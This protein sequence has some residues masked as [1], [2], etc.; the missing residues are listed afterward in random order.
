MLLTQSLPTIR[1]D[2]FCVQ[3][4]GD[5]GENRADAGSAATPSSLRQRP[6]LLTRPVLFIT[7]R[8]TGDTE[9][10]P[11]GLFP[12]GRSDLRGARFE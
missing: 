6:H 11:G 4:S 1:Q 12:G 10:F 5:R 7:D 9:C 2:G 3:L 8:T